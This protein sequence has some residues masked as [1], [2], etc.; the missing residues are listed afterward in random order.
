MKRVVLVTLAFLFSFVAPSVHYEAIRGPTKPRESR[1]DFVRKRVGTISVIK[2]INFEVSPKGVKEASAKKTVVMKSSFFGR[3]F[4]AVHRGK[5]VI[6]T[7]GHTLSPP[8]KHEIPR[9]LRGFIERYEIDLSKFDI[10]YKS[11]DIREQNIIFRIGDK[12]YRGLEIKFLIYDDLGQDFAILTSKNPKD[13]PKEHFVLGS[14][15]D[16]KYGDNLFM[17]GGSGFSPTDIYLSPVTFEQ[18]YEANIGP[19]GLIEYGQAVMTLSRAAVAAGASGSPILKEYSG[20]PEEYCY[21]VVGIIRSITSYLEDSRIHS[22]IF[23]AARVELVKDALDVV[24]YPSNELDKNLAV[25]FA[26][27][28]WDKI[29]DLERISWTIFAALATF[30]IL[31]IFIF[32]NRFTVPSYLFV[33]AMVIMISIFVYFGTRSAL[34][35]ASRF[36]PDRD[37]LLE[38]AIMDSQKGEVYIVV[39]EKT[40]KG[41]GD[42]R[43]FKITYEPGSK[44]AKEL[45]E[46]LELLKKGKGTLLRLRRG[47][48]FGA[49]KTPD[50]SGLGFKDFRHEGLPPKNPDKK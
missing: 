45:G 28:I 2:E 26:V 29:L 15:P 17:A 33:T 44:S 18:N 13:L 10:E 43:F 22:H 16:L 23:Q 5:K 31:L 38:H 21:S 20:C 4:V 42:L 48:G 46:R 32:K 19:K 35:W 25:P 27:K 7:S 30:A 36:I 34:G 6:L 3:A 49:F 37:L 41:F 12:I 11:T 50:L 47:S 40:P 1:L 39:R 9:L 8:S 24:V 14:S